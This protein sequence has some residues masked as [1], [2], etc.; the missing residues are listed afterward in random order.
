[1]NV[2]NRNATKEKMKMAT[3]KEMLESALT[4][5]T[6]PQ[7][8]L[9]RREKVCQIGEMYANL[10][11]KAID[12]LKTKA[13]QKLLDAAQKLAAQMNPT[14]MKDIEFLTEQLQKFIETHRDCGCKLVDTTF[15]KNFAFVVATLTDA[16]VDAW[17]NFENIAFAEMSK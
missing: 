16:E 3:L 12:Q 14:T 5:K 15:P 10:D 6:A 2:T 4:K 9:D 11:V 17:Y 13:T 8:T 7:I 1:M